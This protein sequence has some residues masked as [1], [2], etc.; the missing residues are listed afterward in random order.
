MDAN[1]DNYF[2]IKINKFKN[3]TSKTN[4]TELRIIQNQ[5]MF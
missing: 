1:G 2:L 3:Q 5:L 4:K